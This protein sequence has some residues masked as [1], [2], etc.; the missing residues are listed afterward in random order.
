MLYTPFQLVVLSLMAFLC[1]YILV[2]RICQCIEKCSL[3]KAVAKFN[4]TNQ[5]S[6]VAKAFE[7]AAKKRPKE[8]LPDENKEGK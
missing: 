5:F 4:G 7:E 8:T 3:N 1:L 6:L 2:N